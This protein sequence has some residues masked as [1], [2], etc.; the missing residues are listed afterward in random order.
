MKRDPEDSAEEAEL[1]PAELTALSPGERAAALEERLRRHVARVLRMP[2]QHIDPAEPL[3]SYG[4][5]SVEGIQMIASIEDSLGVTLPTTTVF[6]YPNVT[7]LARHLARVM[8]FAAAADVVAHRQATA[9]ATHAVEAEGL[10]E[11]LNA[12]DGIPLS[13]MQQMLEHPPSKKGG[14]Q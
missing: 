14:E 4:L 11:F 3:G 1:N 2:W 10:I 7:E 13:D 9:P 12:V 5:G 8:G 6:N